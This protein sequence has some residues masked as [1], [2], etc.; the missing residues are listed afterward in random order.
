M[1]PG[2]LSTITAALYGG[3]VSLLALTATF[4]RRPTLRREARSTL[5]VL[6]PGKAVETPQADGATTAPGD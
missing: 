4:A 1:S 6:M 5:A 2:L 3:T